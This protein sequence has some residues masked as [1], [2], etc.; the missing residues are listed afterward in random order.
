MHSKRHLCLFMK[1]FFLFSRLHFNEKNS[2]QRIR[3]YNKNLR[4]ILGLRLITLSARGFAARLF[5]AG[6]PGPALQWR[7]IKHA[8]PSTVLRIV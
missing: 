7:Q 4:M 8:A 2:F 1:L 3:S 6:T 5:S